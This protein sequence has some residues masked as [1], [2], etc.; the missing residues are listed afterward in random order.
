MDMCQILALTAPAQELS[1]PYS[2][3][4]C[5]SQTPALAPTPQFPGTTSLDLAF[6]TPN[7]YIRSFEAKTRL[8][9]AVLNGVKKIIIVNESLD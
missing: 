3:L 6:A 5:P 2:I 4:P 7:L 9:L 1:F 8:T